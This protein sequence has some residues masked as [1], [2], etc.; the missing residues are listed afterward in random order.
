MTRNSPEP[1]TRDVMAILMKIYLFT[2]NL[3]QFLGFVWIFSNMTARLVLEGKESVYHTFKFCW[4]TMFICQILAV[5]EVINPALGLVNTAVFPAMVQVMGR[6]VILFVIFGSLAEMQN[7]VVVFFV[8]YLWSTIEIFRYP[9]YMLASI[10]LEWRLLTWLRY[11]VWTLLYPL[12]TVAEAVAVVQ[13]LSLFDASGLYSIPLPA[14]LGQS[15]SFSLTLKLYLFVMF[16]GLF[17]NMRHLIS[18]R[19]RHFLRRELKVD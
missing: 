3:I 6:N 8:F 2:Y 15:I 5:V 9:F 19:R 12:G 13:S 10:G 17:I 1:V 18:Q 11:T 16:L 14:A 4:T 7:R